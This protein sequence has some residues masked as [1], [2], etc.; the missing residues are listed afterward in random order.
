MQADDLSLIALCKND[1]EEMINICYDYSRKWRYTLNPTKTVVTVF[2]ESSSRFSKMKSKCEWF[3]G[4][5][6]IREQPWYKHVGI[7]RYANQRSVERTLISCGKLR[8]TF[9]S[10]VGVGLHPQSMNPLTG[11]KRYERIVL[12]SAL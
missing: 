4:S 3:L 7:L 1:L 6:T 5:T 2:G 12:P 11:R 10:I 9:N 8:G